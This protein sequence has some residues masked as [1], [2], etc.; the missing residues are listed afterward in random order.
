VAGP[1]VRIF[2]WRMVIAI[3][4]GLLVLLAVAVLWRLLRLTIV[5]PVAVRFRSWFGPG[6]G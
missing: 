2:P 5:E 3:G 6:A 4:A 1:D